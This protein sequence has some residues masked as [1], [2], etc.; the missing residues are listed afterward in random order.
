MKTLLLTML[1]SFAF[2]KHTN[3]Q[4]MV[5]DY[6]EKSTEPVVMKGQ[7][8]NFKSAGINY[9]LD[10][11]YAYKL[12][13]SYYAVANTM[14]IGYF[15]GIIVNSY[16]T[17]NQGVYL[18]HLDNNMNLI[19]KQNIKYSA[20]KKAYDTD[21]LGNYLLGTK[22]ISFFSIKNRIRGKKYIMCSAFDLSTN[23]KK[24][25][26]IAEL[27]LKSP[28]K[29]EFYMANDNTK[30]QVHHVIVSKVKKK[31]VMTKDPI[32]LLI[33]ENLATEVVTSNGKNNSKFT[34]LGEFQVEATGNVIGAYL[35][36]SKIALIDNTNKFKNSPEFDLGNK[37]V[38]FNSYSYSSSAPGCYVLLDVLG[39]AIMPIEEIA[40][41]V[42]TRNDSLFIDNVNHYNFK[43]VFGGFQY[44][45]SIAS[46]YVDR[47]NSISNKNP[48]QQINYNRIIFDPKTQKICVLH[49]LYKHFTKTEKTETK[50][51]NVDSKGNRSYSH[52]TWD[53]K[54]VDYY[55]SG[56]L[57]CTFVNKD[58][59]AVQHLLDITQTHK[60]MSY[61]LDMVLNMTTNYKYHLS[62]GSKIY[63]IN[64]DDNSVN[65]LN[66]TN[67]NSNKLFQRS[68]VVNVG[69][70]LIIIEQNG[71]KNVT[72]S[73]VT[74]PE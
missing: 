47:T 10:F 1:I 12:E 63:R 27:K 21:L 49:E 71:F 69:N 36:D 38:R 2:V 24:T 14:E 9:G 66:Y 40:I 22:M 62:S 19:S 16:Q 13:S 31:T 15:F 51:Y 39:A 59:I 61:P 46:G 32:Q 73:R 35:K 43:N 44:Q 25:I 5:P 54:I 7:N 18:F 33:D 70:E 23:T 72:F 68:T 41:H 4:W 48:N 60:N 52:S 28:D 34:Y 37:N 11:K 6:S 20:G 3:G 30:I 65:Y 74:F 17:V 58:S 56:P 50:H 26:K 29:F 55:S 45:S 42:S 67:N 57:I 53:T 64:F 8:I